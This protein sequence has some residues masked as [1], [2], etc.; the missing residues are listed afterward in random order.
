MRRYPVTQPYK[1]LLALIIVMT[2]VALVT[3]AAALHYIEARLVAT[4]GESLSLAAAEI[5]DKLD[6]ILFERHGDA[7]MMARAFRHKAADREYLT[8]YLAWMK[9]NYPMYLW[10]GVTDRQGLVVAATDPSTVGQDHSRSGWFESARNGAAVLVSDVEPYEMAGGVD[11]VAFTAPIVN[12][13]GEF[14]GTV[15]SRVGLPEM[16]DAL[17]STIRTFQTGEG[18]G[19]RM[20][21]Q[22]LNRT[23]VAFVDSDLSHKGNVNLKQSGLPSMRLSEAGQPG[24]VEEEHLRRHVS[25]VTGYARTRGRGEFTGL[26][27]TVLLRVDLSDIL[28]PIRAVLWRV[29]LAGAVLWVPMFCLLLWAAGSLRTAWGNLEKSEEWLATTLFSIGDAVI[30]TDARGMVTFLNPVAEALTGWTLEE[31]KGRGLEEVFKI[32]NEETGLPVENPV[33]KVLHSGLVVGLANHT[34]LVAKDGTERPIDDSGAPI[35]DSQ[36][37]VLGVV[38]VFHDITARRRAEQRLSAEH[39]VTRVLSESSS[40][41][42]AAPTILR[43]ICETLDWDLGLL[44][45]VDRQVNLLRCLSGWQGPSEPLAAFLA[46]S[47][48]RTFSLGVGLPGRV[49]ATGEA[50]WITDVLRD[51]NFP[52][53]PQAAQAGLRGAFAFPILLGRETIGLLEFFSRE[54]RSPDEDLLAMMTAIGGQIGQFVERKEAEAA[55]ADERERLAVTLRSIGDGVITTDAKGRVTLLN[56]VAETLTGWASGEAEGRPLAEVFHIINE[57]TR[58]RCENPVERVLATGGIVGLA[59][60]TILIAKDGT[61]RF[62]ADSGAPIRAKDGTVIGVVLVFRDVTD[63]IK[64]ERELLIARKLEAVGILA[65]GIA[66]DFNNI[67][68]AILGNLALAKQTLPH[69]DRLFRR[70]AEAEKATIRATGLTKQLLTF[71]KGG[72]PVKRPTAIGDLLRDW[73]GFALR[74]ANVRCEFSL[75]ADLWNVNI[76]EGQMSQVIHNLVLNAQQAMPEGGVVWISGGNV[77]VEAGRQEQP[78]PLRDGPYVKVSIQDHGMGIQPEHLS[79]IFDPYFTTKQ[80]GSGLGLSTSFSIIKNHD[81]H[82]IVQSQPGVGTTFSIYLPAS[83][84]PLTPGEAPGV[85]PHMGQGRILIMDDEEPVRGVLIQMLAHCGYE[86]EGAGDGAQALDLYRQALEAGRPYHAVIM[87]LTIPGGMGGRETMEKLLELVPKVKAIVSS[88]YATDPVMANFRQ[89]GFSG[90]VTKPYQI[91]ELSRVLHQVLTS[92]S[93]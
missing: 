23:G 74:G 13:Q 53:E 59:N 21:Y 3:G 8:D 45:R 76:D 90:V 71:A 57:S 87:D 77:T 41:E 54:T 34:V 12:L 6:R 24:H 40:I 44:W 22:F 85:V 88:G 36:G 16:E 80:T 69:D 89:Y 84:E 70:L 60:H 49:W 4:T 46:S 42:Q 20:E 31:A 56:E 61:E 58:R 15:L 47:R 52:R 38:L 75:P 39:A 30:A 26:G 62:L 14:L 11:S 32:V 65:G 10:L 91:G 35:K 64:M 81:G 55:L 51:R 67:L 48:D 29:G 1:R 37:R 66:H 92:D 27:W 19:E 79:K 28:A 72:Q 43:T 17:T 7:Q 86:A 82:I 25:V 5:A 63:R 50:A 2:L 9:T 78:L 33:T 18:W 68:T 83:F 73:A 93:E